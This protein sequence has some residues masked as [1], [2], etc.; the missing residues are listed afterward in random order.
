MRASEASA[1]AFTPAAAAFCA[2]TSTTI[3]GCGAS[4]YQSTSTTPGV[5]LKMSLTV[6]A[7]SSRRSGS[8]P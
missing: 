6:L 2:S 5:L 4:T 1:A 7:T 3:L 8:G